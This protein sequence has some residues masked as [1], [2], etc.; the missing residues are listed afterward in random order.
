MGAAS[1]R[2]WQ[3][4]RSRSTTE[5]P[6]LRDCKTDG[7]TDGQG[8]SMMKLL[9]MKYPEPRSAEP[10][11]SL[12]CGVPALGIGLVALIALF[13][14]PGPGPMGAQRFL[15]EADVSVVERDSWGRVTY[16]KPAIAILPSTELLGMLTA[17]LCSAGLG[18]YLSRRRRPH[19]RV[20]TCKA[21][22][23]GCAVVL[24]ILWMM[25]VVAASR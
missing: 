14:Q 17:G 9:P 22:M 2:F 11:V 1:P 15:S 18:V 20:T 6:D 25:V 23:I 24:L 7:T 12:V 21:G 10:L 16:Q 13:L 4:D 8:H 3:V 5:V 19:C